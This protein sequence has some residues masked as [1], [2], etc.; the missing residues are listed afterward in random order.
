MSGTVKK[1]LD[2]IISARSG[3]NPTL[4][5]TTKT[6]LIIKGL[7][8]DEFTFQTEDN[9]ATVEKAFIIAKEMGIELK[10]IH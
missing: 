3:G 8:P 1:V 5:L 7:N 9:P 4:A 6:K 10:G 2:Q